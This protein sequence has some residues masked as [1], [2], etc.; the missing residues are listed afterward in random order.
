MNQ[1]YLDYNATTPIAKEV[2]DVMRPYLDNYFGN[3][4]SSHSYGVKTKLAVEKARLQ[5]AK[6]LNC[7]S[8]EVVFTSGGTE[9]NNYAIKGI[10]FANQKKEITLLRVQLN[11]RQFLKC[12]N[13]LSVLVL[14][15]L[16]YL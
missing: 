15:L 6:L 13:I 10:A 3:P 12:V 16:I 8:S 7:E 5:V 4:S 9:S 14:R 11:I 2:A 1:I